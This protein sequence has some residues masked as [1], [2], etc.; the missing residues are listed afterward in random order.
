MCPLKWQ[1]YPSL[2]HFTR[3][4]WCWWLH[5]GHRLQGRLKLRFPGL[6][7]LRSLPVD[8]ELGRP[9]LLCLNSR[10]F[11]CPCLS[12]VQDRPQHQARQ[13][14][15]IFQWFLSS[16]HTIIQ[17]EPCHCAEIFFLRPWRVNCQDWGQQ[18]QIFNITFSRFLTR[19][20]QYPWS[21]SKLDNLYLFNYLF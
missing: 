2:S 7:N 13:W 6:A 20:S 3:F 21:I 12:T 8:E 14:S 4:L 18:T 10:H 19:L 16:Y 17:V 1:T 15:S 9:T 11:Q 5:W